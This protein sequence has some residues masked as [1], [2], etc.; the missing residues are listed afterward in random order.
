MQ[1]GCLSHGH[2]HNGA[3]NDQP[4]EQSPEGRH[5]IKEKKGKDY[6]IDR[7]KRADNARSLSP[8][9]AHPFDKERMGAGSTNYPK[10]NQE[11]DIFGGYRATINKKEWQEI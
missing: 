9:K 4:S 8:D 1:P 6:P 10:N 7:L 2:E 11:K 5:V 3:E